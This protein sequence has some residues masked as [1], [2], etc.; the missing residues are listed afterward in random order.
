MQPL[1]VLYV[2]FPIQSQSERKKGNTLYHNL[3][4]NAEL[5]VLLFS[6]SNFGIRN[7]IPLLRMRL[8]VFFRLRLSFQNTA[9]FPIP[10]LSLNLVQRLGGSQ[11]SK[12]DISLSRTNHRHGTHG[13]SLDGLLAEDLCRTAF[14]NHQLL[15]FHHYSASRLKSDSSRFFSD[16]LPID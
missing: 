11:S 8:A 12:R 4:S 3:S 10:V 15:T 2:S 5:K 6:S 9:A 7:A 16:S 1:R 14:R 13:L